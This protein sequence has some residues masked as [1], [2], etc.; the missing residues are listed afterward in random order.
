MAKK[1]ISKSQYT[2]GLQCVK[3]LWLYNYRKDLQ[4]EVSASQQAVF[5]QGNEVGEWARKYYK[6]GVMLAH[7]RDDIAGALKETQ[8]LIAKG[9][10]LFYEATFQAERVLVRCDSLFKSKIFN[11]RSSGT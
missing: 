8:E 10:K 1:I 3:S 5:D 2:R 7:G 4:E 11:V 6:G 9:T